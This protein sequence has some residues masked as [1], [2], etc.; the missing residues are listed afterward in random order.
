MTTTIHTLLE[1]FRQA[2]TSNREM[3]DKFERLAKTTNLHYIPQCKHEAF[4]FLLGSPA[5]HPQP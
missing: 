5:L 2:K 1:E 4:S 3:G